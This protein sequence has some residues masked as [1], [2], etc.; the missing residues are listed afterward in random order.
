[1]VICFSSNRKLI[2]P[3]TQQWQKRNGGEDWK[4]KECHAWTKADILPHAEECAKFD[5]VPEMKQKGEGGR[6]K[7]REGLGGWLVAQHMPHNALTSSSVPDALKKSKHRC[8]LM[9]MKRVHSKGAPLLRWV[10]LEQLLEWAGTW[11]MVPRFQSAVQSHP[12]YHTNQK[13]P[14]SWV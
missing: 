12:P 6:G 3:Q 9:T 14:L 4:G 11:V 5:S 2:Q 13:V 10:R 1:M 7:E 8:E